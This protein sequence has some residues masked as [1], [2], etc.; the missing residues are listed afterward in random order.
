M[1]GLGEALQRLQA[2]AARLRAA[3]ADVRQHSGQ[4]AMRVTD[5]HSESERKAD[6]MVLDAKIGAKLPGIAAGK[7]VDLSAAHAE[8]GEG[9]HAEARRRGDA[10]A[11][12]QLLAEALAAA[13][14][15]RPQGKKGQPMVALGRRF[16]LVP[17]GLF[18]VPEGREWMI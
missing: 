16:V 4:R 9:S 15:S 1:D 10:E 17:Q 11:E 7:A 2:L 6:V 13:L 8:D 5:Y 3:D 14:L 12:K 18:S